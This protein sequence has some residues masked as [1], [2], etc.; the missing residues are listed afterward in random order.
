MAPKEPIPRA[1]SHH[2]MTEKTTV[3]YPNRPALQS[4]LSHR[5]QQT[6]TDRRNQRWPLSI[7]CNFPWVC[8]SVKIRRSPS[9]KGLPAGWSSLPAVRAVRTLPLGPGCCL[10]WCHLPCPF[11]F[12]S[13]TCYTFPTSS[14]WAHIRRHIHGT[15]GTGRCAHTETGTRDSGDWKMHTQRDTYTGQRGLEDAHTWRHVHGTVGTGKCTHMEAGT[16]DSGDWKIQMSSPFFVMH[17]LCPFLLRSLICC[18]VLT[19]ST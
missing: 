16:Q 19:N 14:T 18:C 12:S 3:S 1:S 7:L 4:R 17:G 5:S 11:L 15:A 2:R 6:K 8:N 10:P 9:G 13:L